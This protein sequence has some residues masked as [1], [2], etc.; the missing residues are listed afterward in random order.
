[1]SFFRNVLV[2][3]VDGDVTVQQVIDW[4]SVKGASIDRIVLYDD[5]I[6][7]PFSIEGLDSYHSLVVGHNLKFYD[8]IWFHRSRRIVSTPPNS[9]R[10]RIIHFQKEEVSTLLDFLLS[11]LPESLFV[12]PPRK[13]DMNK[14]F[15]LKKAKNLGMIIPQTIVTNRKDEVLGFI[16]KYGSSVIK[17]LSNCFSMVYED[18]SYS[19]FTSIM[20]KELL[21]EQEDLLFPI[22]VQ[23][24]IEKKYEVRTFFLNDSMY[25]MAIFSQLDDLCKTDWR[26]SQQSNKM[27]RNVPYILPYG[28]QEK[29]RL[30][31]DELGLK[32][33]SIDFILSETGDFVFLEVNPVGQFGMVSELCNYSLYHKFADFL[34]SNNNSDK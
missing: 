12:V 1:M 33:G 13:V 28:I 3:A 9:F 4:M 10:N 22:M 19:M 2:V 34:L 7:F 5:N 25:S 32:T 31:M 29:V 8:K 21:D 24:K 6:F 26:L 18:F 14:L 27:I 20:K 16:N 15:V 23:K 11:E 17:P 30:L